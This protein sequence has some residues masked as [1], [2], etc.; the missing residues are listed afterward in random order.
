MKKLTLNNPKY[1]YLEKSFREWL[2]IL[3]YA[4]STVYS[5]PNMIRE[6]FFYLESCEVASIELVK[7]EHFER[8]LSKLK[9]RSNDRRGG[10]LSG[11]HINKHIQALRKLIEYLDKVARVNISQVLL[12]AEESDSRITYLTQDEIK[13]LFQATYQTEL[14]ARA[15]DAVVE[16]IQ[17][18]DR[19]MLA[20]FYGCGLRR[21]E[22]VALDVGDINFDRSMLHVRQGKNYQERF[23]PIS[24]SSL[25]YL[26]QYVYDHRGELLKGNRSDALFVSY[27]TPR[28]LQGQS[29]AHR[30]KQLQVMTGDLDLLEKEVTLHVL[31]HSIATHLLEAGMKLESISRF[32]GHSSLESTQIYTHLTLDNS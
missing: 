14:K 3:G 32:L 17:S 12:R 24:K 10:G 7:P 31:R 16:A 6:F 22:G 26:V 8:Y 2:D 21:S 30:L 25:K 19:A 1:R 11:A 29:L 13:M 9:E 15:S 23:V 5:I 4:P 18:R 27:T 20:V 28:R